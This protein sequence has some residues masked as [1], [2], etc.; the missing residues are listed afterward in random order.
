MRIKVNDYDMLTNDDPLGSS[1]LQFDD[2]LNDQGEFEEHKDMEIGLEGPGGG[3]TLYLDLK[4]DNFK[5]REVFSFCTESTTAH[6]GGS[7]A[8]LP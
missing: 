3:G 8:K 7:G 4:F 6:E 5:G 2:L 1:I